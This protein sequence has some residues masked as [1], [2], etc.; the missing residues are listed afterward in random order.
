M[1][2]R[3]GGDRMSIIKSDQIH[4]LL[5][6]TWPAILAQ[7]GVPA[8]LLTGKH[9]PC[10][11]CGGKDRF[12]FDNKYGR[13]D[14]ICNQCGN[15]NGFDLLEHVHGWPY[16]VARARVIKAAG[17]AGTD[18]AA[19]RHVAR[20]AV[21]APINMATPDAPAV[22]P[23]HALRLRRECCAIENCDDAV[24]YLASRAL[25]PLPPGCT[26]RAHSSVKYCDS[27]KTI[28][29]YPALVADVLDVAGQL[30]TVHVTWLHQGKKLAAHQPRK[31][32]SKMTSRA[33]C[34]VRLMPATDVL[35]I[36]EGIETAM[37]AAVLD[38][39]PVWAATMAALL[40]SFEPPSN[41]TTLRVYAD[42]DEA[43]HTAA[44]KLMERLQG[45]VRLELR[46]PPAPAKDWN[47]FLITRK[48]R[49]GGEGHSNA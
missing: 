12:R 48:S 35:G 30:V 40:A 17:F 44:L 8:I 21:V 32:L 2:A 11:G 4:A 7:L 16:A 29:W 18:T 43:G 26:L 13:G 37:S 14:Y 31:L 28:G 1:G 20:T 47:D 36:A 27:G 41:V 23:E 46:I 5:G 42:R 25:W 15:G 33:G 38:G 3:Q 49:A 24:D 39:I 45:C 6:N 10:P 9:G 19:F 34:A 22:P